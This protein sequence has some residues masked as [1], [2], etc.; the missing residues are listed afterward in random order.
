MTQE[1]PA[2]A[3]VDTTRPTRGTTLRPRH[4][5]VTLLTAGA[6]FTGFTFLA[7]GADAAR[8]MATAVLRTGQGERIGRVEFFGRGQTTTVEVKLH[9]SD[10]T[11]TRAFHGLHVHANDVTENGEGCIADP[12]GAPSAAFTSADGHLKDEGESHADHLGDMPSVLV[13]ANGKAAASFTTDRISPNLLVGKAVILHA[14]RDNFG[15]VPVGPGPDQYT[16]NTPLAVTK[17]LATGNAGDRFACGVLT[18]G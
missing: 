12:L 1:T 3:D 9:T 10:G 13:N 11:A 15:N 14:G 6:A 7:G 2:R 16:A 17:T 18:A 5:L 8:P 4:A